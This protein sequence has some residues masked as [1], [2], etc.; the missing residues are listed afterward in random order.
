MQLVEARLQVQ[1][2]QRTG[3]H[4]KTC[5]DL[6]IARLVALH[7]WDAEVDNVLGRLLEAD[8]RSTGSHAHVQD[9]IMILF[10]VL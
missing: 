6:L 3:R 2:G 7:V 9:Q 1:R 5:I 4:L 8:V 10:V